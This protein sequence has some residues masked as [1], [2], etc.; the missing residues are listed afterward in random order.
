MAWVDTASGLTSIEA[1]QRLLRDGPNELPVERPHSL[2]HQV[3]DVVRE[4]ML[5]LLLAASAIN[6][7]LAEALDAAILASFVLFVVA[8]SLYQ[9]R[10]T[11]NAL[12]ALRNLSAPRA[13]VL[14]DGARV[15][16][17]GRDVVPGDV[18]ILAEGDRVPADGVLVEAINL[19]IDESALTGE[20]VAVSK[21]ADEA[22]S[23]MGSPGGDGT[24]WVF[25]GTLVVRGHGTAR[26]H[27][28]GAS[29]ALGRI[30]GELRTLESPRTRLQREFNRLV[31]VFAA[32]GSLAAIAVIIIYGLTRGNWLEAGLAGITTAMAVLPEEIPVVFSI[33]LALGAWRMSKVRVLTRRPPV[34]ETL[35][36]ATV[37]CVDKTGT[38][39]RN[40]MT[41]R[42]IGV[43]D[44]T[45]VLDGSG[46]PSNLV[47]LV[48]IAASACS[49][50]GVDPMDR[51]FLDL[52]E[53]THVSTLRWAA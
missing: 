43:S 38:L 9:R 51:A 50:D 28:T 25:S 4:P 42:E 17:A 45:H 33:F 15:R 49:V 44:E 19:T 16:I 36:S 26:I 40:A 27:A 14:R 39:T 34:I 13:L 20:S 2:V 32:L 6:F 1:S 5:L 48:S 21:S 52:A 53:R 12:G 35:G 10:K 11:E 31:W 30:G 22:G 37:V 46:I 47:R 23:V 8:I 24:P 18:V 41:V 7:L 3:W 29:T